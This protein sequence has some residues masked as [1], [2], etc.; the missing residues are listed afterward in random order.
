V[1]CVI[2]QKNERAKERKKEYLEKKENS[3]IFLCVFVD[4]LFT[5]TIFPFFPFFYIF[6]S[7][8]NPS[9][10]TKGRL[11]MLI[12]FL[13]DSSFTFV[14]LFRVKQQQQKSLSFLFHTRCVC[15]DGNSILFLPHSQ[16]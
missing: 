3:S 11:K 13:Y 15:L 16:V 1:Q 7:E 14:S 2:S 10:N 12:S 5:S 9:T 8:F 4:I 6:S